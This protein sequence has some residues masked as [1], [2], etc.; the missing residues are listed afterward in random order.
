M[1]FA[2]AREFMV[3]QQVRPWDVLDSRVLKAMMRVPREEFV[4]PEQRNLAYADVDLPLGDGSFNRKPVF[5]GRVLQSILVQPD[6]SVL[7]IGTG[8]GYQTAC[9]AML[10]K[11]VVTVEADAARAN[12]AATKLSSM[13]Y[14]NVAVVNGDAMSPSVVGEEAFDVIVVNS[15]ISEVPE[16]FLQALKPGGRMFFVR[17]DAPAMEAVV[18]TKSESGSGYSTKAVFETDIPYLSGAAPASTFVL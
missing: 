16:N 1:D 5:Q 8:V 17:G 7:E 12:T 10:A 3:E 18:L 2:K 13:G 14:N 11:N 4:L 6:E 15:A 9:L